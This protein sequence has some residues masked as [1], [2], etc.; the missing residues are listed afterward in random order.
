[1]QIAL[2]SLEPLSSAPCLK[3][4][5]K[6]MGWGLGTAD[7]SLPACAYASHYRAGLNQSSPVQLLSCLIHS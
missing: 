3:V 5:L 6:E 1:M 7:S 4:P 2:V